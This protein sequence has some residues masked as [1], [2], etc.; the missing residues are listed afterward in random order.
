[1]MQ[2][3]RPKRKIKVV[4]RF[5]HAEE[6]RKTNWTQEEKIA[7]YKA[8]MQHGYC[9]VEKLC[10]AVPTKTKTHIL[11]F[12]QW[13]KENGRFKYEAGKE[14]PLEK[15]CGGIDFRLL[16]LALGQCFQGTGLNGLHLN[17]PTA[18]FLQKQ[19]FC[20]NNMSVVQDLSKEKD[21]L[22]NHKLSSTQVDAA[23]RRNAAAQCDQPAPLQ[24]NELWN[25]LKVP[26]NLLK[27]NYEDMSRHYP[28][29]MGPDLPFP[30]TET[31]K[32]SHEM[33]RTID[34]EH[35]VF[36][37]IDVP[38]TTMGQINSNLVTIPLAKSQEF[39]KLDSPCPIVVEILDPHSSDSNVIVEPICHIEELEHD[40]NLQ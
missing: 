7:F 18:R 2:R 25:P 17:E 11:N 38:S 8:L 27:F 13:S 32:T 35:Y 39:E 16:Y 36:S 1:M 40:I 20:L 23:Y 4:E 28:K 15:K 24:E 19:I 12:L 33:L 29:R 9:D 37:N 21:L 30:D 26:E 31:P 6:M 5:S 10:E 22:D 3:E 34:S 14:P